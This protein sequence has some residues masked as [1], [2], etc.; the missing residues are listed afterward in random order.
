VKLDGEPLKLGRI[1]FTPAEGNEGPATGAAIIDGK[2][3]I[4]AN[5][6]ATPGKNM[7]EI[8][9]PQE[10]G[11]KIKNPYGGNEIVETLE[12]IPERYNLRSELVANIE[13]GKKNVVDFELTSQKKK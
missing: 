4:P 7:V 8:R 3:E 11:K 1:N 13:V 2:Y 6:G 9:A 10:T 5:M 12:A